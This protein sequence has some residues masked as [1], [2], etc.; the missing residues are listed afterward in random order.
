MGFN[1]LPNPALHAEGARRLH[2]HGR[3]RGECRA[4]WQ[5][6]RREQE[7]FAV[8]SHR[9]A[10]AAQAEGRFADEIVPI[11]TMA[12]RADGRVHPPGRLARWSGRTEAGLRQGRRG[13]G[14]NLLAADGRRRCGARVQRGIRGRAGL[15]PLARVCSVAVAGCAPEIMGMGPVAR[16]P[17]GAVA[18]RYRR[19]ALDVV[20]LNEAF[21]SQAIACVRELGLRAETL[22]LDGGAIALGHPLGATGAR[23]VGKAA[24]RLQRERRPLCAR[25]PVHRRGPGHRDRAGARVMQAIRKVGVIGA[26]TMGA[27]IAAQV[28][29]AGVPVLLLDI[30]PK[31]ARTA[32]RSPR[33]RSPICSRPS[34]PPSCRS[35][36][37]G[38][39]TTGNVEDHLGQLAGM[40]L[41]RRGR[42]RTPGH[43]AG[44]VS[45]HRGGASSGNGGIL[46]HVDDPARRC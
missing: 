17:Q 5:I 33:A 31:G 29:N 22:N 36:P 4:P 12:R 9:R 1:P 8:R 44:A 2:R 43:Q 28:A 25:D 30:V 32:T 27:G 23:I 42:D 19:R 24:S 35:A 10:A 41:D 18:R 34:P 11:R 45:P 6:P 46:Q 13:D 37:R 14:R 21:A 15:D 38:S 39:S 3:D 20:E 7:E 40:R 26:G 16:E